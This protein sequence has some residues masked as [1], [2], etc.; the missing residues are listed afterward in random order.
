MRWCLSLAFLAFVLVP[1]V[2]GGGDKQTTLYERLGGEKGIAQIVDDLFAFV[3][4]DPKIRKEHKD[5]FVKGDVAGLKRKLIDQLGEATGGPQKYKGKNMKDAHKGLKITNADFN[6][7]MEDVTKALVKNKVEPK[8]LRVLLKALQKMR[9]DVVE[10][11]DKSSLRPA[12]ALER[13]A[14]GS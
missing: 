1:P 12:P 3:A 10:V 8:D 5:H 4:E 11:P 9:P 13:V 14:L 7:L 6:A 2:H